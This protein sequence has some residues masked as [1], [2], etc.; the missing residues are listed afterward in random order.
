MS[1]CC[2]PTSNTCQTTPAAESNP[3]RTVRPARTFTPAV[4]IVETSDRFTLTADVTGADAHGI[5]VSF[6]D[7]VLMLRAAVEPR[8]SEGTRWLVREYG[9]GRWERTFRIGEGIDASR[10]EA[11][12]KNGLLTLTLPKAEILRPRKIDVRNS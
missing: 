1:S 8:Q 12:C 11:V 6:E 7:G 9:V 2:K 3:A 4:D 10:I 5:D